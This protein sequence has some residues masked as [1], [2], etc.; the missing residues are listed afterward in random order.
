[1]PKVQGSYIVRVNLSGKRTEVQ[2]L[3]SFVYC[4]E[5]LCCAKTPLFIS[6]T[7]ERK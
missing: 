4:A 5:F 7:K 6:L 3:I 1:M 2:V